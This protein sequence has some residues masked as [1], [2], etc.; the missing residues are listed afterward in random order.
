MF[1]APVW[2][3]YELLVGWVQVAAAVNPV[4]IFLEAGRGLIA[5][6]PERLLAAFA[7]ALALVAVMALWARGGLRSAER[8]A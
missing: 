6:S 3:P 4:T 5:G 7:V 1:L 2:V 8:A